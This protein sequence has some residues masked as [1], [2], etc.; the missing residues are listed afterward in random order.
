MRVRLRPEVRL[1][2]GAKTGETA[3]PLPVAARNL[4][5]KR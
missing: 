4:A 5:G 3:V 2:A 1:E